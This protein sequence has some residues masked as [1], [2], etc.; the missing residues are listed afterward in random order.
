MKN[1][2]SIYLITGLMAAG[3]SKIAQLLAENIERSVH[4]RGDIFRKM[5]ISDREEMT[6]N[7]TEEAIKQ[8]KLRY[9]I[10]VQAAK[11]YY[12]AGFNVIIQDNYYG[13]ILS[14]MI[15]YLLPY[16]P[17]VIVLNP[18]VETIK[19]REK[20]RNKKGYK[21]FSVEKLY[22]E[23]IKET[24]KIG[25]WIDTSNITPDETVK[26]ILEYHNKRRDT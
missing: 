15:E 8:L 13:K 6:E 22:E 24:P 2:L 7:A 23:F 9:Q 3:K 4:L 12:D 18:N 21:G 10:T 14:E 25:F 16:K 17:R 20:Y 19:K 5:I 1:E 26:K 11:E